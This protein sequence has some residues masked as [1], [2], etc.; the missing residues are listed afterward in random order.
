MRRL[1]PVFALFFPAPLVAEFFL[2][3]FPITMLPLIVVLAPIYGGG[4]VLI[5]EITR[6]TGRGWPTIVLLALAFGLFQ[7]GLLTQSLFNP[8][9][10]DAHVLDHGLAPWLVFVLTLHTVWSISVP[11]ALVEEVTGTRPWL[12]RTGLAVSAGLFVF[13][14]VAVFVQSY[15][16]GDHFVAPPIKLV[17]SAVIVVLLVVAAFRVPFGRPAIA[18]GPV[19]TGWIMAGI[20][21]AAGLL[22]MSGLVLPLWLG[23]AAMIV[24]PLAVAGLV[25]RWSRRAAWGPSQRFGVTAGALLTYSWEAFTRHSAGTVVDL[26]SHVVYALGAVAILYYVARRIAPAPSAHLVG[27]AS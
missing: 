8:D 15:S 9:Y 1:A 16:V 20:A 10:L 21:V 17:I 11:V 5:R 23:V 22:V 3:D 25:L 7:E 4:A 12:G 19:P 27:V 26:V 2:G 14:S 6:R 24:A 18:P 13:G